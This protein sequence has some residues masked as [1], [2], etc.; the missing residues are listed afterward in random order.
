MGNQLKPPERS[1]RADLNLV[2]GKVY[3]DGSLV[4]CGLSIEDGRIRKVGKEASLPPSDE[5]MSARGL[6]ILPGLIDAHVHMRDMGLSHKED[7]GSG[8]ASAVC[9]GFTTVLDMPNTS[10]PTDSPE[11]LLEKMEVARG[12]ILSNVGL[13]GMM[14]SDLDDLYG[15]IELGIFSLKIFMD[16]CD[17]PRETFE[18]VLA[19][20]RDRSLPVTF[21]AERAH[22]KWKGSRLRE[23][24]CG[25]GDFLR[26]HDP[27]LEVLAV[28]EVIDLI[29]RTGAK[30]H[31][32]HISLP[33]SVEK[34]RASR[35]S[36]AITCEV[37]PHHLL[38]SYDSYAELGNLALT[39][40]PLRSPERVRGLMNYFLQCRIDIVAS[41]HAPHLRDEKLG[42]SVWEVPP[43]IPGLETTFPLLF[44]LVAKGDLPLWK[45]IEALSEK[46]AELFGIEGRGRI[47]EGFMADLIMV[48]P[49]AEYVL[50]SSAFKSKAKYSP[51]DGW[52]V[53]G[54]VVKTIVN[55]EVVMDEGEIVSKP[56][57]GSLL[58]P[59]R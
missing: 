50:D 15:M 55:G 19:A 56:G 17:W 9:G 33:E 12:R 22:S 48:D 2:G 24:G 6:I 11:R 53:R 18:R 57:I 26:A 14:T 28:E 36:G 52:R 27:E 32:C 38:L 1:M 35:L 46:P 54:R 41:D 37:T 59:S 51:F 30:G 34:L 45:M 21:H 31:I 25:I 3:I 8:T 10:P 29:R 23:D 42:G 20:C 16:R 39:L 40:P 7:F 4:D 5:E 49:R 43:G 13:H 58:R 47:R 44:T